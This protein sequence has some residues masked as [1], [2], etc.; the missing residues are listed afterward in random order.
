MNAKNKKV[1]IVVSVLAL[2][3]VI[4]GSGSLVADPTNQSAA[5]RKARI[6][7][8]VK[9]APVDADTTTSSVMIRSNGEVQLMGVTVKDKDGNQLTAIGKIGKETQIFTINTNGRTTIIRGNDAAVFDDVVIGATLSVSGI[10]E[11]FSPFTVLA[12]E[13]RTTSKQTF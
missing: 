6:A 4:I 12:K 9:T 8:S 2:L 1:F 3:I 7:S 5:V 10:F 13:I 11:R